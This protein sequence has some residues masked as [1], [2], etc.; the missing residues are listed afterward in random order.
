MKLKDLAGILPAD[1]VFAEAEVTGV[2]SDSRKVQPGAIFVAVPG[3]KA[4]GATLC[5]RRGRARRRGD[6]RG[7][8]GGTR[9]AAISGNFRR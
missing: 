1:G 8:G 7:E 9:A 3:T 2:S 4:D 5:R 6:R